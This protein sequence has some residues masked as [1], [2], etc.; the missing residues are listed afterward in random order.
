MWNNAMWL[1]DELHVYYIVTNLKIYSSS[2]IKVAP[3]TF[4]IFYIDLMW[5][6]VGFEFHLPLIQDIVVNVRQWL[7]L[8]PIFIVSLSNIN[9]CNS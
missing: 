8:F 5:K 4:A 9:P 2:F 6:E 3:S 1:N 7:S